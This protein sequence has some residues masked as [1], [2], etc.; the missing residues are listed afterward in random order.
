MHSVTCSAVIL[1]L[2]ATLS[3]C[4]QLLQLSRRPA[5]LNLVSVIVWP[6]WE[7]Y[8]RISAV[9]D[10]WR[11][12]THWKKKF[13]TQPSPIHGSTQPVDNS[14]SKW[15]KLWQGWSRPVC[16]DSK[17]AFFLPYKVVG[18]FPTRPCT[19]PTSPLVTAN[20]R[21]VSLPFSVTYEQHV[22]KVWFTRPSPLFH[23]VVGLH[24]HISCGRD[25][26]CR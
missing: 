3:E 12:P 5:R 14:V 26:L 16:K 15:L 21:P 9:S 13:P 17:I 10:P 4:V 7:K 19:C 2:H 24:T 18:N 11:N 23:F 22:R 25:H 8:F 20:A 6:T 1:D